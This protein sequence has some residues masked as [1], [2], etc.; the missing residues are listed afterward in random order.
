MTWKR[1]IVILQTKSKF[2]TMVKPMTT[3]EILLNKSF[4]TLL[5]SQDAKMYDLKKKHR[6]I[7]D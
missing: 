5:T 7:T 6:N 2:L 4:M 1:N 3:S